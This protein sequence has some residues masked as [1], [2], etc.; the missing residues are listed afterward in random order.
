M[1]GQKLESE[2]IYIVNVCYHRLTE[3]M[4]VNTKGFYPTNN[5]APRCG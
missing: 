4:Q 5:Q 2:S 1:E 3:K